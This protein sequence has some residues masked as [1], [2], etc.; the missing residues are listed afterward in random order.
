MTY[1]RFYSAHGM[2]ASVRAVV[3]EV[4]P[5]LLEGRHPALDALREQLRRAT[6]T[7][8]ELSG[9]GFFVH[10]LVPSDAPLADPPNVAGGDAELSISGATHGAGCA[11]FV[12]NGR[13][14]MFEGFT[15]GDEE[16]NVQAELLSVGRVTPVDSTCQPLGA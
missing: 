16:W 13:L 3:H 11:L 15:Y 4:L 10:L 1:P 9:V 5:R 7:S 8:V 12:E 14:S 6:I 2:P